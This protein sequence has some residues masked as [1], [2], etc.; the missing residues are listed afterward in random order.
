MSD[1]A[2]HLLDVGDQREE[3]VDVA[4]NGEHIGDSALSASSELARARY[5]V[6]AMARTAFC[7]GVSEALAATAEVSRGANLVDMAQRL[8]GCYSIP[9]EA[10]HEEV[11]RP[12]PATGS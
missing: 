6:V 3:K 11:G 4:D 1:A 9:Y 5:S 2:E 12:E 10:L 7:A 8:M